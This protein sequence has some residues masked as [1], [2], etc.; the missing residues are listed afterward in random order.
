MIYL[1]IFLSHF[2]LIGFLLLA[3]CVSGLNRE[4]P[5]KVIKENIELISEPEI[6]QIFDKDISPAV[7]T[8]SME[9]EIYVQ[10]MDFIVP[11]LN[12]LPPV[13]ILPEVF[14][15]EKVL[16]VNDLSETSHI[17][18]YTDI[19]G[20]GWASL[21]LA[22]RDIEIEAEVKNT[23]NVDPIIE[24][25][26]DEEFFVQKTVVKSEEAVKTIFTEHDISVSVFDKFDISLNG[27]GWIYLP[28]DE[29]IEIKYNG[30][31]FTDFNTV[32]TFISKSEGSFILRFQYQDLTTNILKVEKI[33]LSILPAVVSSLDN[34][35]KLSENN[36][37]TDTESI[38]APELESLVYTMLM[39]GD[40]EGLNQLVPD[41]LN[42]NKPY[43]RSKLPEIA[44]LLYNN[45]YY[46]SSILIYEML[47]DDYG[48]IS[49]SDYY[50]YLLGVMY[51][52][53]SPLRNEQFSA[54]YYKILLDNYP[55]SIYWE[56][57][58]DRYRFL[59]R[60]YID[61]R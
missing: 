35:E 24:T 11:E 47:I 1:K 10:N 22:N 44:E 27:L 55:A 13:L 37:L 60:R 39:E 14:F 52:K 2:L 50:L 30:R 33:N 4:L 38:E 31:Q 45:S 46:S 26:K 12:N 28:D 54:K 56:D 18:D 36:E 7:D 6:I 48:L 34:D 32:Y 8:D 43:V 57:S 42:N 20:P 16:S 25:R 9:T 40:F 53:E 51:E 5:D 59:K 58:Q 17:S 3:G 21:H 49:V 61:I 41:L 15:T 29:N 23:I 19:Y